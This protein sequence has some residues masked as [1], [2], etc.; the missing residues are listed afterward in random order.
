MSSR[1]A[2]TATTRRAVRR[3]GARVEQRLEVGAGPGHE[4]DEASGTTGGHGRSVSSRGRPD[5]AGPGLRRAGDAARQVASQP[6]EQA[7][8]AEGDDRVHQHLARRP[9]RRRPSGRGRRHRR[10]AP[11]AAPN[12]TRGERRRRPGRAARPAS[13]RGGRVGG[14]G[15]AAT[16]SAAS[17]AAAPAA[18]ASR[19]ASGRCPGSAASSGNIGSGPDARP[20]S[21]RP[22]CRCRPRSRGRAGRR[23]RTPRRWAP[24]S[25]PGA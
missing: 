18:R 13:Q 15:C 17:T 2:P 8:D 5:V 16:A 11:R 7:A 20:R 12:S 24:G 21:A 1:S 14:A 23:R 22:G 10:R 19:P 3:V 6:A 4:H 25:A 9:G